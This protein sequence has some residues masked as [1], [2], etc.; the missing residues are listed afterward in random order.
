MTIPQP[1]RSYTE[2]DVRQLFTGATLRKA[3]DYLLR[4]SHLRLEAGRIE[5]TVQGSVPQPYQ[6]DIGFVA[7]APMFAEVGQRWLIEPTCSCPVGYACKHAAAVMLVALRERDKTPRINPEVVQWAEA[8]RAATGRQPRAK[9]GAGVRSTQAIYYVIAPNP[10]HKGL[11]LHLLKGRIDADHRR[12]ATTAVWNNLERALVAPPQFVDEIDLDIFRLILRMTG[13]HGLHGDIAL[14]GRDG[15]ELLAH[16]VATGRA[17]FG[18]A[19]NRANAPYQPLAPAPER[20][21]ILDW[22]S[23]EGELLRARLLTD[24]AASHIAPTEPPW[25]IDTRLGQAGVLHSDAPP[26]VLSRLLTLPALT[27]VDVAVVAEVLRETAPHLPSPRRES[28]RPIRQ[29]E[30]AP[31]PILRLRTANLWGLTPHRQYAASYGQVAYDY[32]LVDFD[33]AGVTVAPHDSAEFAT[34]PDG[35]A[36]R[37]KRRSAEEQQYLAELKLLGFAPPPRH[38][39]HFYGSAAPEGLLGLE[40]EDAWTRF[41]GELAPRLRESGWEIDFPG[42]FRHHLQETGEW[43]LDIGPLPE[44]GNPWFDV[45][46]GIEVEGQRIELAPLLYALFQRDPRWL[47]AG[48]LADIHDEERVVLS[49][50]E[51][52]RFAV[53]AGRL[54]PLARTL[55]DLFDTL[56][57]DGKLRISKFDA[58]RLAGIVDS[59]PWRSEGLDAV[60]RFAATLPGARAPERAT[61]PA[62]L[63]LELRPYQQEGI[64]WLQ[65]LRR[66]GLAGILADDMGLG[67]TAQTL[68][69]LLLEKEGGRLDRPALIVLPTS[70]VF[71]WQ[72]EAERFAPGLRVLALHGKDRALH[73]DRIAEHD[74]CLTTYPLLWR[75]EEVLTAQDWHL[76][77]LD[78]AQTVKNAASKAAVVVRKLRA[79]HRLCLTGTPLENHLGELWAQFDFLLPGFLGDARQF[80]SAWRTPIEKHGNTLRRELLARR[81]RPFVLRRRKDDVARDLPP[82][83]TIVRAVQLGGAQRDLYETV[84]SAMDKQVRDA[85]SA[86]GFARSQIVILDA[87]LKLRQVC[88]D[89]RLLKLPAAA[90]VRERAKLDLLMDVLPEMIDEGRRVLLFSQFTGMLDLIEAELERERLAFVRLDGQTVDRQTPIQ[91]FQNG[92]VPIFLISLKAGGVGL[93]LTAADTVIHYDPWWNPAAENQA[94]DRAHRIGQDKPVFVYKLVVAGSIEEKILALQEKKAELAAGILSEDFEGS[95]KFGESDIAAL[96]APLPSDEV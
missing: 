94:T 10:W 15:A 29:I 26:G 39:L 59:G 86:K 48:D 21:A 4:V 30:A 40:S 78:E 25:Y 68:A 33:Y 24:P 63:A 31:I 5:A 88:C 19:A 95:A 60:Q 32:A 12:N 58:E 42:D 56:P 72:R 11:H 57:A 71:N 36:V 9:A 80:T 47:D 2:T 35:E 41:F 90:R 43:D 17:Y 44:D 81:I 7:N 52:R 61:P 62:G 34:L 66:H 74:V 75:D 53:P 93:N 6:V 28:G 64:D 45:T 27:P 87:L 65:H 54:K 16:V 51:N 82:K 20:P 69:H 38:A 18:N 67:K 55:I 3:Q 85:I 22:Q 13:R 37:I 8:L 92:E 73:F 46:L 70:L 49:D 14:A 83:T 23:D 77:I 79:R 91:R 76:L 50:A 96:L 84:R 1:T 89:P